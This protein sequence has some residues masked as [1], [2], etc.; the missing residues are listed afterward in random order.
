MIARARQIRIAPR[1][2]RLVVDLVRGKPVDEALTILT[3]TRKKAAKVVKDLIQ[4]AVANASD[5]GGV[6]IDNL[7]VKTI[8]VD[9][10]TTMKRFRSAPMGRAHPI[11][12][13]SCHINV[14]L[15]EK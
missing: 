10:G 14:S 1:K 15:A 9:G 8:T 6:D 5:K 13:R 3:F 12:K 4:S 7:F 11:S 2:A